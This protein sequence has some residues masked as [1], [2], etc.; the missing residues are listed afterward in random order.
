MFDERRFTGI[1]GP[2]QEKRLFFQKLC[3]VKDSFIH[4][5]PSSLFR[6]IITISNIISFFNIKEYQ[7]GIE[8]YKKAVDIDSDDKY[9]WVN[10][11]DSYI[12]TPNLYNNKQ[13]KTKDYTNME[14]KSKFV[15][16]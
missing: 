12:I 6:C 2:K 1:P 16:I 11:G 3:Q 10:M 8:C 14:Y 4:L 5:N 15:R 7:K 9:V 13:I